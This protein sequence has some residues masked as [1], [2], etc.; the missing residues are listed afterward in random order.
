MTEMSRRALLAGLSAGAAV[1]AAPP[2]HARAEPVTLYW[3]DL[4]PKTD[5]EG[6]PIDALRQSGVLKQGELLYPWAKQPP[7]SVVTAYNDK[8]VKIPGYVVPLTMSGEGVL[9][10]LLVLYV[11]ACIHVPPPPIN[12][13]V[14]LRF[15]ERQEEAGLWDPVWATGLLSTMAVETELAETGYM[16]S[17]AAIE[18]YEG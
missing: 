7:A 11:G 6:A 3:E 8:L 2:L 13:I 18:P 1:A 12:Q 15:S 17:E 10:G 14:F 5:G 16:M 4:V 9:E